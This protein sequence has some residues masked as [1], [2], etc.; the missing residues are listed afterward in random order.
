MGQPDHYGLIGLVQTVLAYYYVVYSADWRLPE[1]LPPLCRRWCGRSM[2][3]AGLRCPLPCKLRILGGLLCSSG[4]PSSDAS[5][6]ITPLTLRPRRQGIPESWALMR[7]S[8]TGH[9]AALAQDAHLRGM[10]QTALVPT[11]EC[12]R[13]T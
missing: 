11:S 9:T 6:R 4:S 13:R 8:S 10:A 7:T 1:A 12:T 3:R 5:C 2:P